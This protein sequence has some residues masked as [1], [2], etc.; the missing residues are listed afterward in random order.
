[1]PEGRFIHQTNRHAPVA[2]RPRYKKV[3]SVPRSKLDLSTTKS[4][5]FRKCFLFGAGILTGSIRKPYKSTFCDGQQSVL[6]MMFI[7]CGTNRSNQHDSETRTGSIQRAESFFVDISCFE[8][9]F[10]PIAGLVRLFQRNLQ[11]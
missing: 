9:Q 5:C 2:H 8:K 7:F 11:L 10:Q 3:K 6:P 4:T 1:M